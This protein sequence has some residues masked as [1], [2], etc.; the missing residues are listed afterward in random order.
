M[1]LGST[2]IKTVMIGP[3]NSPIAAGSHDWENALVDGV[4]SYS[5]EDIWKGV[6]SSYKSLVDEVKAKTKAKLSIAAGLKVA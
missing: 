2:R 1:E 3:D 4:W 6:Q 5:I